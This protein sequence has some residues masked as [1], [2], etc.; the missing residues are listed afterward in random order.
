MTFTKRMWNPKGKIVIF[1]VFFYTDFIW[2]KRILIMYSK[3]SKF[4]THWLNWMV[5][6]FR[7]MIHWSSFGISFIRISF[8]K[9]KKST[10]LYQN[11]LFSDLSRNDLNSEFQTYRRWWVRLFVSSIRIDWSTC[12][13][14][15]CLFMPSQHRNVSAW[16]RVRIDL[17]G[18]SFRN[19]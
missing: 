10:C 6:Y 8:L 16:I 11:P 7:K 5:K 14:Y 1:Q 18:N 17:V 9:R 19:I 2:A 4:S 12:Q 13:G 15:L 3:W